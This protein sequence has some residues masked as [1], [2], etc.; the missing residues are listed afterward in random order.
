MKTILKNGTYKRV[1]D[2]LAEKDVRSGRATYAKKS[3]WKQAVRDAKT[4]QAQAI[5]ESDKHQSKKTIKK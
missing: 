5:T 3:D 2:D 1:S 4:V